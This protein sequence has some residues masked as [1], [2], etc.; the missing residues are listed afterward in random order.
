MLTDYHLHLRPDEEGTTFDRYFTAE[1]VERYRAAAAAAGIEELGVSEHV[2]RF[3]QALDLWRH[4]LWLENANDDLDEYC[5]FV[6]ST[7]LRLGIECDFVPGAEGRTAAMLEARDFDYVVGSVHFV[8]EGDAAVDHDGF[9]VWEALDGDPEAIWTRY[10]E[11]FDR[12]ARSGLFDILAHPDLVK[13]WGRD[14][15]VPEGDLRR[16]YEPAVEA[17]LAGGSAVELSTAG[18]RKPVGELYPARAF[19]ELV[20]EAGVPFALSSDAHLPEQIGFRYDD[21]LAFLDDLGVEEVAVFE[22][23]RRRLEPL[24]ARVG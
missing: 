18:L 24:G 9:D 22:G 1:N 17:I 3:R 4:P 14:R 6:R 19:A 21:A 10:F 2:Y 23:R 20:V 13:V 11:H 7:P 15:P 5:E 16:F 8:G 12:C